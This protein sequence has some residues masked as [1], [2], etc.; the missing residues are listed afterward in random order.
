MGMSE[1]GS[2]VR[3][4]GAFYER[5]RDGVFR[6]VVVATGDRNAAEDAVAEA[7]VRACERWRRVQKHPSP[8]AWVVTV[9]LN[10]HRSSL[11]RRRRAAAKNPAAARLTDPPDLFDP[12]LLVALRELPERQRQ[13]LALRVLLDL[14]TQQTADALGIAAGTVTAHLHRA[15]E[16]LRERLANEKEAQ[17]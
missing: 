16:S 12:S 5:A 3:D 8:V 11:R 2:M 7:F 10:E 13:V 1:D 4:F 9:A 14:S 6:A 15:L 17:L